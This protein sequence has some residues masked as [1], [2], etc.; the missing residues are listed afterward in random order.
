MSNKSFMST[1]A[2]PYAEALLDIATQNSS[3]DDF[4]KNLSSI[5]SILSQSRELRELLSNPVIDNS[6]KKEV[7][8]KVFSNQ[9]NDHILNFLYI[10][11]DR[12]RISSLDAI[13]E[14]YLELNYRLESVVIAEVF[15]A[16]DLNESQIE[17]LVRQ[18]KLM[19]RSSKVK[20]VAKIDPSLIGGFVI[21]IGSKI[22]DTS[23]SGKLNKISLYLSTK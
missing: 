5:S 13:I 15:S 21:K 3:I 9:I 17:D 6:L 12:R 1:I 2:L 18:I 23:L 16:V 7:I 22:I 20:L 19:T 11:V 4:T 8:K 10:L 14:K